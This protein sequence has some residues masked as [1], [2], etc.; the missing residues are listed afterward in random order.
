MAITEHRAGIGAEFQA[1]IFCDKDGLKSGSF[2]DALTVKS[3]RR[4]IKK[5]TTDPDSEDSFCFKPF[6]ALLGIGDRKDTIQYS[7][8]LFGGPPSKNKKEPNCYLA[9]AVGPVQKSSLFGGKATREA[10]IVIEM[11][12]TTA[13]MLMDLA[14]SA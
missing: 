12:F 3:E 7:D 13:T 1:N 4:E 10:I 11:R 5:F 6:D 2:L 14:E 9:N 8:I